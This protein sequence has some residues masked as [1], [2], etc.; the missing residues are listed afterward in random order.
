MPPGTFYLRRSNMNN[1]LES[2]RTLR[3]VAV[4]GC[5][6]AFSVFPKIIAQASACAMVT[7]DSIFLPNNSAS[8]RLC[9]YFFQFDNSSKYKNL[10]AQADACAINGYKQ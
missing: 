4:G 7:F 1:L 5:F 6:T 8:V 10:M 9:Y 3:K 2:R